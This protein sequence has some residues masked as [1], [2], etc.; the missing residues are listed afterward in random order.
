MASHPPPS[1]PPS[2]PTFHGLPRPS[3][4]TP[5]DFSVLLGGLPTDT[6]E[7]ARVVDYLGNINVDVPAIV[8]VTLSLNVRGLIV[9]LLLIASDCFRLLI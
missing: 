2:H 9:L 3:Q 7:A 8:A 4:V 6:T 1:H 5:A